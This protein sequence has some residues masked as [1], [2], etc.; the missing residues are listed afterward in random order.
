MANYRI[1][2]NTPLPLIPFIKTITNI[3]IEVTDEKMLLHLIKK[4]LQTLLQITNWDQNSWLTDA[5]T[6]PEI[7][8]VIATAGIYAPMI[9][10]VETRPGLNSDI[11]DHA[12]WSAIGVIEGSLVNDTFSRDEDSLILKSSQ[13]IDKNQVTTMDNRAIHRICNATH[14]NTKSIHVYSQDIRYT[15]RYTYESAKKSVNRNH[16]IYDITDYEYSF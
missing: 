10:I 8:T 7:D 4:E 14:L 6:Q 16:G 9:M 1:Y 12:S 3:C 11:H 15:K 2:K 5:D 13:R